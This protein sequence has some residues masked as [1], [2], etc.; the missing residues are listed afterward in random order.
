VRNAVRGPGFA[1]RLWLC[2]LLLKKEDRLV[3]R[4]NPVN[5]D[6]PE[7]VELTGLLNLVPSLPQYDVVVAP[8]VVLDPLRYPRPPSVE[9]RI[10]P[11]STSQVMYYLANGVEA[12]PEHLACGFARPVVD[13]EGRA[14]DPR[15]LTGGLFEVHVCQGH[16]PPPNAYVAVK[17][18]DRWYYI[19][20]RDHATKATLTLMLQLSRLDFGAEK[21]S[22]PFLTL[23]I[24]R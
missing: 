14:G 18:R 8:G 22:G 7:M 1:A 15:E 21:P 13:P 19:D 16:K 24:G 3:F 10:M 6:S 2:G 11:R 5:I 20:D 9:L 12:P 17:Y 23:P 4:I